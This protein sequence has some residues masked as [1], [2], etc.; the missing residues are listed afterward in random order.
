MSIDV[1]IRQKGFW[2]KELPFKVILGNNL[3][4]GTYDGLRLEIGVLKGDEFVAYN[5]NQIGRGFSVLYHQGRHPEIR[6]RL[7]SPTSVQELYDFYQ[8]I[9]R[10]VNCW[11]CTLEVDGEEMA[12]SDFQK[13]LP[14]MRRFN[15][16]AL[17]HMAA[18]ILR[19]ERG[20]TTLFSALWPLVIGKPEAEIF[21]E[22]GVAAFEEWLHQKQALDAYY[23][24][25]HF[26]DENGQIVGR[27]IITENTLSIF[28]LKGQ[29]P[30][31][32]VNTN[33]NEPLRCDNYQMYLYSISKDEMI[34]NL[35]YEDFFQYINQNRV[36][37]YDAG[38]VLIAPLR[39][40][41]LKD[42]LKSAED[43][44]KEF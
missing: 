26:F 31:G 38:H 42:A 18:E 7:L 14:Q 11:K 10:I 41:E 24:K 5:R 2:K 13:G 22:G 12:P 15:E 43:M 1:T 4:Y 35:P 21:K 28:P 25:P 44:G 16:S 3:S 32:T 36:S 40:A 30:F 17:R 27:Y 39:L 9:G 19:E 29:V 6:L 20:N 33:T 23:A 37:R 34:G 8:C